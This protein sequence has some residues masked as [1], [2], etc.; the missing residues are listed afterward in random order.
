MDQAA[1]VRIKDLAAPEFPDFVVDI[2]AM[3]ADAPVEL[4]VNAVYQAAQQQADGMAIYEDKGFLVRYLLQRSR[5]E[6]LYIG[7]L[8][9]PRSTGRLSLPACLAAAL[10]ACSS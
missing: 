1:P 10:P 5:M 8:V 3:A 9:M 4:S 2:M 6:N 7:K